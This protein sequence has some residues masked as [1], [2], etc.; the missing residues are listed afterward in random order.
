MYFR[1]LIFIGLLPF[2]PGCTGNLASLQEQ[3]PEP[4]DFSSSLSREYLSFAESESELGHWKNAEY[5][6]AK[7][8]RAE[9]HERTDPETPADWGVPAPILPAL[10]ATRERLMGMLDGN[11]KR[12]APYKASRAQVFFDCWVAQATRSDPAE[13]FQ[14]CQL[15][16][17]AITEELEAALEAAPPVST[18]KSPTKSAAKSAPES[19]TEPKAEAA[20][21]EAQPAPAQENTADAPAAEEPQQPEEAR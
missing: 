16:L 10:T 19:T 1:R 17:G 6:A 8:R 20:P 14:P 2:L 18:A 4:Y 12:L 3:A 7:G 11:A 9:K 13:T 15:E 5:F 21:S